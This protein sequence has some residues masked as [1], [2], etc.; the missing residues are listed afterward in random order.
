MCL[1]WRPLPRGESL[2]GQ[3]MP[4]APSTLGKGDL[5][6]S[7]PCLLRPSPCLLLCLHL[8]KDEETGG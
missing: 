6:W 2:P 7:S 8:T 3:A 5:G 1:R 4:R